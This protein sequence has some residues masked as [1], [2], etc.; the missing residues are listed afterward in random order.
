MGL[1]AKVP[2]ARGEDLEV[3]GTLI[4]RNSTSDECTRYADAYKFRAGK[5]LLIPLGYGAMVNHSSNPNLEKIIKNDRVYLRALRPV[6]AGE[7][8]LLCY[9]QYARRAFHL[10]NRSP[11]QRKLRAG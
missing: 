9:S 7:E 8:L 1:F 4:A 11:E 2:L 5:Y 6:R 3:I 10:G